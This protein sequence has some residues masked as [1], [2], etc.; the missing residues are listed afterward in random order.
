MSSDDG[1]VQM[2]AFKMTKACVKCRGL[3]LKC[4]VDQGPSCRR[5]LRT[6]VP[7]VFRP[8]ANASSTREVLPS[9]GSPNAV[10]WT[11]QTLHSVLNR[12]DIIE[13]RLDL[14]SA[15]GSIV[16]QEQNMPQIDTRDPALSEVW[17]AATQLRQKTHHPV[18]EKIWLP[19]NIQQLWQFFHINIPS[20]HFLPN[21]QNFSSPTPLLLSAMLYISA[22][23]HG[24]RDL[25]CLAPDYFLVMCRAIAELSIPSPT[26]ELVADKPSF[27]SEENAFHDVLGIVLAGL[28]CEASIKT[29]GIW[30]SVG[31]RLILESCPKEVDERSREWQKLF[32]GL[33][34]IDLEHASL[35]MSCPIIP[36]QAPL[37]RLH[38]SSEDDIYS[39]TQMLHTG[40]THFTGRGLPTIW[41]CFS[42]PQERP[43]LT[44]SLT[45][46]DAAI[47]RDWAV[48]LDRWLARFNKPG[49]HFTSE[50]DRRVV[51]RQY[52]LHRLLV[53]S[54]YHPARGFNLFATSTTSSERHELLVSTRAA[55]KMQF[56][57][58]SIWTN[59]DLVMITWAALIVL[60]AISGGVGEADDIPLVQDLL[61]TLRATQQL[62]VN[63]RHQLAAQLEA[64]LQ[65]TSIQPVMSSDFVPPNV[66][67]HLAWSIFDDMSIRFVDQRM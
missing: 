63:F 34:I 24:T 36:L 1:A 20:L 32:A 62:P 44:A 29:T 7:C 2:P 49:R 57:D 19:A 35:H 53:L 6:G 40:L 67:D 38:I 66:D 46:V 48:Q 55:L 11:S 50:S 58:K 52:I 18:N 3:K 61:H 8:R 37:A 59:W 56:D 51:F 33:Q 39:L 43:M 45:A 26:T 23:N 17:N 31:Y 25:A 54:I 64:S 28:A 13:S 12:L 21:K 65:N 42:S 16:E 30:I 4:K 41:S 47:I 22:L 60:Q 15:T 10:R 27:K 5:C 9:E 14:D